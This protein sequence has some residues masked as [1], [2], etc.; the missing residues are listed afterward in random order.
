D[1]FNFKRTVSAGIFGAIAA[2]PFRVNAKNPAGKMAQYIMEGQADKVT[3]AINNLKAEGKIT[4]QQYNA[5]MRQKRELEEAFNVN[6]ALLDGICG[7]HAAAI[8]NEAF[9][10]VHRRRDLEQEMAKVLEGTKDKGQDE[11]EDVK[12]K[13]QQIQA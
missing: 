12:N 10:L 6:R 9:Q 8:K 11:R 4:E 1:E 5:L 2:S 7:E 3:D 13:R